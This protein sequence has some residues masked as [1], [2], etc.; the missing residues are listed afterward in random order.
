MSK[1]KKTNEEEIKEQEVKEETKLE[2][3]KEDIK[4]V[5]NKP[6]LQAIFSFIVS[7][8]IL[9]LLTANLTYGNNNESTIQITNILSDIRIS[10]PHLF[11]YGLFILIAFFIRVHKKAK[12]QIIAKIL[13]VLS[14]FFFSVFTIIV[15]RN[16]YQLNYLIPLH[17]GLLTTLCIITPISYNNINKDDIKKERKNNIITSVSTSIIITLISLVICFFTLNKKVNILSKVDNTIKDQK[18]TELSNLPEGNKAY[19][20]IINDYINVRSCEEARCDKLGEV[21]KD[22]IYEIVS[23][24][25]GDNYY[26]YRILDN[27]SHKGY[28]A[29]PK[30]SSEK[31]LITYEKEANTE[32]L[33]SITNYKEPE[34]NNNN[35]SENNNVNSNS[36][37]NQNNNYNNYNNYS[38]N[39][40]T[41]RNNTTNNQTQNNTSQNN[42]QSNN[43]NQTN[44]NNAQNNNNQSNN[45]QNN[46]QKEK[47]T[48]DA[49][50]VYGC[51]GRATYDG[52]RCYITDDAE[53]DYRCPS[54]Y[55]HSYHD[56]CRSTL[57]SAM[58]PKYSCS[59]GRLM[60]DMCYTDYG[61]SVAQA[62]CTDYRYYYDGHTCQL[63]AEY[64][65]T[66]AIFYGYKCNNNGELKGN[67]CY[68]Y[69][70]PIISSY[71]CPSGYTLNN[72]KCIE[73]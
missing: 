58:T 68:Y 14:S 32:N 23:I 50:P 13:Y 52:S 7:F 59:S 55:T 16:G 66:T 29:N 17:Y 36:N 70:D 27:N 10:I 18:I 6:N 57:P 40:N 65:T 19:V 37:N 60:G 64:K 44:N 3:N 72:T 2:D 25:D 1:K 22:D 33:S 11:M 49:T 47:K 34:N 67:M 51:R 24:T 61:S 63:K 69:E 12:N 8:F 30:Y 46:T 5:K 45:N 71:T 9:I 15:A 31:Y 4:V 62:R 56:V 42:N 41:S 73:D 38:I 53:Y 21:K 54:G 43:S 26:W 20:K 28:I 35:T 48:I 39:N